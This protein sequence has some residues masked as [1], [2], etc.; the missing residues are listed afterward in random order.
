MDALESI[1]Q[2]HTKK[3]AST[4]MFKLVHCQANFINNVQ[5]TKKMVTQVHI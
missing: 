4:M 2:L 1:T 5:W 3:A